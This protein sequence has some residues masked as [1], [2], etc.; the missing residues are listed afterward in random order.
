MHGHFLLVPTSLSVCCNS[1]RYCFPTWTIPKSYSSATFPIFGFHI[2]L[3]HPISIAKEH[4]Y[5]SLACIIAGKNTIFMDSFGCPESDGST[6]AILQNVEDTSLQCG[7]ILHLSCPSQHQV[8]HPHWQGKWSNSSLKHG[9][10]CTFERIISATTLS[11]IVR[12]HNHDGIVPH[13]S[14]FQQLCYVS[15]DVVRNTDHGL[16][17]TSKV[18]RGSVRI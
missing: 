9:A 11:S 16:V 10:F 18:T 7:W 14:L 15:G 3:F 2:I 4:P 17:C 1:L 6:T 5:S 13:V 12:W 8:R